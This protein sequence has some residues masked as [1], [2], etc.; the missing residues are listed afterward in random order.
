MNILKEKD[1]AYELINYII[2]VQQN[3]KINEEYNQCPTLIKF[4]DNRPF[5]S[6]KSIL[7]GLII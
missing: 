7:K 2:E 4:N 5:R 1:L 6:F 3:C